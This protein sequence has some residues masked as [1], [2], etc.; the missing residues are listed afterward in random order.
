MYKRYYKCI[1][2]TS[3][4]F[5]VSVITDGTGKYTYIRSIS[6]KVNIL[7]PITS[8]FY[9][10]ILRHALCFKRAIFLQESPTFFFLLNNFKF[11]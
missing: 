9:F 8:M 6:S 10:R 3:T 4:G 11:G 1:G 5:N 2:L 7:E